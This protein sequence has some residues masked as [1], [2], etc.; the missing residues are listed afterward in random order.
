[1]NFGRFGESEF[2][3]AKVAMNRMSKGNTFYGRKAHITSSVAS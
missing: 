1:M 2:W 3:M